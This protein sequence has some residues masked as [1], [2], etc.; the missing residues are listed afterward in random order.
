[1]VGSKVNR[2]P[3][4]LNLVCHGHGIQRLAIGTIPV[5]LSPLQMLFLFFHK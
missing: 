1:M 2:D 4:E 5:D 3:E